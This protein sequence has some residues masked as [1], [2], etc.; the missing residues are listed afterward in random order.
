MD[1]EADSAIEVY[2]LLCEQLLTIVG[3]ERSD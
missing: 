3:T 1:Y 2:V